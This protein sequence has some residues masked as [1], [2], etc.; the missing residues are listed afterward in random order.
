MDPETNKGTVEALNAGVRS[1][2]VVL[3]VA[4]LCFVFI[5]GVYRDRMIVS[6]DAFVG[7]L[8]AAITWLFKSRDEKQQ[9]TAT[10]AAVVAAT[11][12]T[13]PPIPPPTTG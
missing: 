8:S 10:T 9:Q 11:T 6:T 12:G 2:C 5:L 7:I 4:T 13:K 1:F 3:L